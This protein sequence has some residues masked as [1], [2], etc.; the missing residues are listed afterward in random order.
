MPSK[1]SPQF[2]CRL[3]S[4]LKICSVNLSK[5]LSLPRS[6]SVQSRQAAR[7]QNR[8][9]GRCSAYG[10]AGR[11]FPGQNRHFKKSFRQSRKRIFGFFDVRLTPSGK[12]R[13]FRILSVCPRSK[14][15]TGVNEK[16][17]K[18]PVNRGFN[19]IKL[20]PHSFEK[21]AVL[22][23]IGRLICIYKSETNQTKKKCSGHVA[24]WSN[25]KL[26]GCLRRKRNVCL[27]KNEHE[28]RDSSLNTFLCA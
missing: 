6:L 2:R 22:Q 24:A 26:K 18:Y 23:R 14:T 15:I 7:K 20:S 3:I 10:S 13:N 27:E 8:A 1:S 12:T 21:R 19:K 11:R 17:V 16:R 4:V 5:P 28:L 9:C 25:R